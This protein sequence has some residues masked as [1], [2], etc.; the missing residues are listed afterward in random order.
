[1]TQLHTAQSPEKLSL[2]TFAAGEFLIRQ[3]D[4]PGSV[5]MLV[6]GSVSVQRDDQVVCSYDLPGAIFGEVAVLLGQPSMVGFRATEETKVRV[7]EDLQGYIGHD[8]EALWGL[9]ISLAERLATM[10]QTY[11]ETRNTLNLLLE[12]QPADTDAQREF[13]H[14]VANA[15]ENFNVFMRKPIF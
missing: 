3:S 8:P 2:R 7:I 15:W 5:F 1:M 10:D 13:K 6:S 11:F 14:R 4:A 12:V 9:S